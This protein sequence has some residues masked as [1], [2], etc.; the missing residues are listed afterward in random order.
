MLRKKIVW[1]L[2]SQVGGT[3]LGYSSLELGIDTYIVKIFLSAYAHLLSWYL[4]NKI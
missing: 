2:I 3:V 4:G 1:N